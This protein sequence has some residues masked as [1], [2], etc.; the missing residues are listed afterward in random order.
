MNGQHEH[1]IVLTFIQS[2][3]VV[4][5]GCIGMC[6]HDFFCGDMFF[7]QTDQSVAQKNG[8]CSGHIK[9]DPFI[10]YKQVQF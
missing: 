7:W 2:E 10:N 1:D 6:K 5:V 4:S 3:F 9:K 8:V